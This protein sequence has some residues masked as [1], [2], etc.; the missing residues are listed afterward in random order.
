MCKKNRREVE[1][2]FKVYNLIE[3]KAVSPAVLGGGYL[4]ILPV[5]SRY[6]NQAKP[7][8]VLSSEIG[9]NSSKLEHKENNP[10]K[11]TFVV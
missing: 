9:F 1:V 7:D 5:V 6:T 2:S 3:T 11:V 8:E 4:A 10:S